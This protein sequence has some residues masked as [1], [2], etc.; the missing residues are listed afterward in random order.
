VSQKKGP[1]V[2]V[3]QEHTKPHTPLAKGLHAPLTQP[4][5]LT[6]SPG[7][8]SRAGPVLVTIYNYSNALRDPA[9]NRAAGS[10]GDRNGHS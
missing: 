10:T 1:A 4:Q 8:N 5:A 3:G 2:L 9:N 7:N 6:H